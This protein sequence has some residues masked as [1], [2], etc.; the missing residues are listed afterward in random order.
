ME[1]KDI[2]QKVSAEQFCE[3]I[4]NDLIGGV[5]TKDEAMKLLCEYTERVMHLIEQQTEW[6]SVDERLPETDGEYQ[7][8][9]NGW[10]VANFIDG[11]WKGD[12]IAN[13]TSPYVKGKFRIE[14]RP[15]HWKPLPTAP[16]QNKI[17]GE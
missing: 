7:I 12:K 2:P 6:V 17:K 10:G 16:K 14:V 13:S 4:L 8:W 15:T 3:A 9:D 1:A 11:I 5:I